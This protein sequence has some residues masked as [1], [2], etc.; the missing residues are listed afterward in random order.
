MVIFQMNIGSSLVEAIEKI[1]MEVIFTRYRA[2]TLSLKGSS[3]FTFIYMCPFLKN[4]LRKV[5]NSISQ[6]EKTCQEMKQETKLHSCTM[7]MKVVTSSSESLKTHH[8][9]IQHG[10]GNPDLGVND[11]YEY[12]YVRLRG[13]DYLN[14]GVSV[15]PKERT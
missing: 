14:I 10:S 8:W 13:T 11:R 4:H 9:L 6:M 2:I 15:I 12:M 1:F 5:M 7:W 3:H